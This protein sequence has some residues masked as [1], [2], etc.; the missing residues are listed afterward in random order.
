MLPSV[1]SAHDDGNAVGDDGDFC[2]LAFDLEGALQCL[3]E[4]QC[5]LHVHVADH[6]RIAEIR[7]HDDG[8]AVEDAREDL[9]LPLVWERVFLRRRFDL[10]EQFARRLCGFQGLVEGLAAVTV[11]AGRDHDD[12]AAFVAV[13][14]GRR[15]ALDRLIDVLVERVAAVRRYDDVG[16]VALDF[17]ERAHVVAARD[18]RFLAVA[19]KGGDDFLFRVDDDV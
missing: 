4:G 5:V 8:E 16:R 12:D 11:V 14:L 13:R 19:G 18:V 2:V 6:L 1:F 3:V 17:G 10:I 9:H 15:H 7:D